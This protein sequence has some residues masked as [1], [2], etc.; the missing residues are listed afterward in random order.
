MELRWHFNRHN[1]F[2]ARYL[3]GSRTEHFRMVAFRTTTRAYR[4]SRSPIPPCAAR[5][6][7]GSPYARRPPR[8]GLPWHL[9]NK[10]DGSGRNRKSVRNGASLLQERQ[11]VSAPAGGADASVPPPPSQSPSDRDNTPPPSL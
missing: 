8:D 7:S 6:P 10:V 5:A 2:L 4:L 1:A 9:P 3:G 11:S